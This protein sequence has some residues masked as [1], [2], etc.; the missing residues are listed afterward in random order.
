MKGFNRVLSICIGNSF[1]KVAKGWVAQQ[2]QNSFVLMMVANVF[3]L[4]FKELVIRLNNLCNGF[5]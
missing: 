5:I 1:G 2:M 4:T 3:L